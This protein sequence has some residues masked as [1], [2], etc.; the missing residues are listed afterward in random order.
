M[1]QKLKSPVALIIMDGIGIGRPDDPFNAVARQGMPELDRLRAAYPHGQLNASGEAVGLPDG[2]M[3]NSEVGH[4]NIGAGRVVYQELT[5]ISKSIRDGDFFSNQTLIEAMQNS[6]QNGTGA[7]HLMG[8]VS[9]GGVHSHLE[10]IY[11]LVELARQQGISELYV[12]AFLDGRDV[13]PRS[14][15]SYLDSLEARLRETG[16][17][18]IASVSGR[19]YAMDRD[20][21]WERVEKAYA[22]LVYREGEH[23]GTAA[24]AVK[25]AY[26]RGEND[27]FVLPT[28]VDSAGSNAALKAGDAVIFF[29]FRPDRAREMTWALTK[30]EF[31]GFRRRKG[32][33][34]LCYVCMTKYDETMDLPIAYKPEGLT[35]ILSEVLSINGFRQLRIAETEKYAHVTFFFNGG[36]EKAYDG[37]DRILI[38][39][40][41]VA[42]YDLQPKMSAPE[43][44]ERVLS[45][46]AA[47]RYDVIIMNYANGDMVGHTGV[48]EA[49]R[50]AVATVDHC[51]GRVASAI[52][53]KGG[54]V[55]ITADHGN[56]DEMRDPQT[57]QP[58]T[59]HTTNPVP[60]ILASERFRSAK[61]R[62]GGIL[63]DLAPTILQLIGVPQPPQMTG[64]SLIEQS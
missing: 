51:V 59:A 12:H 41:K 32:F 2:Q 11:A 54:E 60:V 23:A 21:R 56:C 43:V 37:E 40:P 36:V 13:P 42:T 7:V 1:G 20:K 48:Y 24:E 25:K 39:S 4:L 63:A 27:E 15:L 18:R 26:A 8:L 31:D 61:L 17:G 5:R 46:I 57:N 62:T 33:F 10:H 53:A 55:I 47:D 64:R 44:T 45:E 19:Y 9:D 22:M 14:A 35:N 38:P 16:L 50:V 58:H 29:N 49:A 28:V 3:G 34:P 52:L 30:E 6:R